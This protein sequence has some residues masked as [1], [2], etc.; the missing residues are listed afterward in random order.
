MNPDFP[1][2]EHS[3]FIL[4][5]FKQHEKKMTVTKSSLYREIEKHELQRKV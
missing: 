4:P 1:S 2:L 5:K 3:L